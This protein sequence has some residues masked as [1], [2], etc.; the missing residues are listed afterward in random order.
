MST[1]RRRQRRGRAVAERG[2]VEVAHAAGRPGARRRRRSRLATPSSAAS[3]RSPSTAWPA[4]FANAH[5]QAVAQKP[6][7]SRPPAARRKPRPA[8]PGPRASASRSQG[9]VGR[10]HVAAPAA[11][12]PASRDRR[13]AAVPPCSAV[14]Q[15]CQARR[16][17]GRRG[18]SRAVRPSY[19][20]RSETVAVSSATFWWMKELANR[21]SACGPCATV[22]TRPSRRS[23]TRLQTALGG[24]GLSCWSL[25]RSP[26]PGRSGTGPAPSG[27]RCGRPA[28]VG[29]CRSWGCP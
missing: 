2:A 6:A 11:G 28:A 15:R 9:R 18:V 7:A 20:M 24:L 13:A 23:R 14:D 29:P 1:D 12:S 27:D 4:E 8:R 5:D 22:T 10:R 25:I 19:E 16:R 3:S 26:R 17:R 21:V